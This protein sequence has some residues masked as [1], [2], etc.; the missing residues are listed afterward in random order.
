M[1]DPTVGDHR[2][3]PVARSDVA[4]DDLT[5]NQQAGMTRDY[6]ERSLTSE[7]RL[8]LVDRVCSR[9]GCAE[10]RWHEL[11]SFYCETH[12]RELASVEGSR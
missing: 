5:Q 1:A 12:T 10:P 8:A 6:W 11:S 7:A 4:W 2:T 9:P 3:E